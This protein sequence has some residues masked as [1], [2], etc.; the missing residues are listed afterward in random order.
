[1]DFDLAPAAPPK[2]G[3]DRAR[4]QLRRVAIAAEMAEH[5]PLQFSAEQ[6]L[7]N[8]R[9]RRVRE[10]AVARLDPLFHRPGP[11]RIGLQH[12]LV[13]VRLDD[14]RVHLAQPLDHHLRRVSKIGHEPERALPRME[15]VSDRIDRVMR[16]GKRLDMNIANRKIRAGLEEP[17]IFVS[18]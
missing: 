15:R 2:H 7:D 8:R 5:D 17:P 3:P 13:V 18:T 4:R 11:M 16:H 6:L 12:F 10:V 1:M 14:E 9:G